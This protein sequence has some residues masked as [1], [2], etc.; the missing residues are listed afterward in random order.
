MES[1]STTK[2]LEHIVFICRSVS[3][4]LVSIKYATYRMRILNPVDFKLQ[5]PIHVDVQRKRIALKVIVK[6]PVQMVRPSWIEN[7]V[8]N[9]N[10]LH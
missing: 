1:M 8:Q 9:D 3:Y 7:L 6:G 10:N 2:N 4:R 5:A